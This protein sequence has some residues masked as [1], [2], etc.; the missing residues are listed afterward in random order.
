M[1]MPDDIPIPDIANFKI[2]FNQKRLAFFSLAKSGTAAATYNVPIYVII[3]S[4]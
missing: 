3:C 2:Y 4:T 1:E